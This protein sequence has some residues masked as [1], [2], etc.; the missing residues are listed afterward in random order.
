MIIELHLS[1]YPSQTSST[2]YRSFCWL[3]CYCA[4]SHLPHVPHSQRTT[5]SRNCQTLSARKRTSSYTW[6]ASS[7]SP[8]LQSA[9]TRTRLR[10]SLARSTT[11]PA[12]TPSSSYPSIV[13]VWRMLPHTH[14]RPTTRRRL[15][16]CM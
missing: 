11:S 16:C 15:P 14:V 9:G 13:S 2:G 5:G 10:S 8:M 7:P 4:N 3:N 12:K 1:Y 6:S